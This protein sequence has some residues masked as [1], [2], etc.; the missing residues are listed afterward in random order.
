MGLGIDIRAA[1]AGSEEECRERLRQFLAK[2][3]SVVPG[4]SVAVVEYDGVVRASF[5]FAEEDVYFQFEG[6][7][8]LAISAKTNGAGPGYHACLVDIFERLGEDCGLSW[9]A[10][11]VSDDTEYWH[12]RDF[13]ELQHAMADW[14][15]SLSASLVEN[16]MGEDV[17]GLAICMGTERVPDN[18]EHYAAHPLGWLER[19]FFLSI[20]LNGSSQQDCERF[21]IWW[22]QENGA[23]FHLKC[24]ESMMWCD[25]NW[26]SPVTEYETRVFTATLLCLESAWDE[27][28]SL[29]YPVR[30]WK[31]MASLSESGDILDELERRFPGETPPGETIGYLRGNVRCSLGSGWRVTLPGTMH[32][33]IDGEDGTVQVF[34]DDVHTVRVTRFTV[35]G[36]NISARGLLDSLTESAKG[37]VDLTFDSPKEFL[38]RAVH[39]PQKEEDG[40]EYFGS[41]LFAAVDSGQILYMSVFYDEEEERPWAERLFASCSWQND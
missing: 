11:S 41:F 18:D 2:E 23:E 3:R 9:D 38:A 1:Y 35:S 7:D 25:C 14:L 4:K 22:D 19:D 20:S 10:D 12:N 33:D 37:A 30:E 27:N 13:D 8:T 5:F 17:S 40:T 29:P 21:F 31:E 32:D 6:G 36:D 39:E 28:P 24:A 34:W 16:H 26:L 15:E